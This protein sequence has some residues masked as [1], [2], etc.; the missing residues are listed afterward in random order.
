MTAAG[1][2]VGRD[3]FSPHSLRRTFATRWREK[4]GSPDGL[5]AAGG[6]ARLESVAPYTRAASARLTAEEAARLGLGNI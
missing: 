5:V 6:W 1:I 3:G 2:P 4:G